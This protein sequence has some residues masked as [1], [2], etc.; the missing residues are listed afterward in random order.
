VRRVSPAVRLLLPLAL[1]VGL[2]LLAGYAMLV[3]SV[4]R[5]AAAV[6]VDA[7]PRRAAVGAAADATLAGARVWSDIPPGERSAGGGETPFGLP[8]EIAG[9]QARSGPFIFDS[10][11]LVRLYDWS[12]LDLEGERLLDALLEQARRHERALAP[13]GFVLLAARGYAEDAWQ[14]ED[15][16]RQ[17]LRTLGVDVER[18]STWGG[19]FGR[20]T[21]GYVIDVGSPRLVHWRLYGTP[22]AAASLGVRMEY[23]RETDRLLV[24]LC[25]ADRTFAGVEY[26]AGTATT[27]EGRR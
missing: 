20:G 27:T 23:D 6:G 19:G 8:D 25:Y 3:V 15:K 7:A 9:M 10:T 16:P 11:V 1:G 26:P 18:T 14:R 2:G 22:D 21:G 4:N 12:R 24:E 17:E 5:L 13:A